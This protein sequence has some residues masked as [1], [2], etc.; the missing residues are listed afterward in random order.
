MSGLGVELSGGIVAVAGVDGALAVAGVISADEAEAVFCC[1]VHAVS[2]A[3]ATQR[4]AEMQEEGG[5]N[6]M[7]PAILNRKQPDRGGSPEC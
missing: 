3:S 1:L 5:Q 7:V 2:I 6:L 4:D